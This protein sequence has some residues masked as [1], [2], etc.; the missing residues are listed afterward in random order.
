MS[1]RLWQATVALLFA[2][3]LTIIVRLSW[4]GD[5]SYITLRTI[6]NWLTGNGLTWNPGER[7][8][9]YTHP[10]WLFLLAAGRSITGEAFFTTLFLGAM[11]SAIA[12]LLLLRQTAAPHANAAVL[13]LLIASRSFSD[14]ATSGLENPLAYLLLAL[15]FIT[16]KAEHPRRL[17]YLS[18]L[19][20][21]LATTRYDFAL[22]AGPTLLV[23]IYQ[24]GLRAAMATAIL[25][26]VPF[27]LWFTFAVGYYGTPFPITAYAKAFS[28]GIPAS[29]LLIQGLHY[30]RY[31]TVHEPALVLTTTFGIALGLNCSKLRC[32]PLAIGALLYTLY[33]VKVGGDFMA[34]RFLTSPF[35]IALAIIGRWLAM[36]SPSWSLSTIATAAI[37]T[38]MNGVPAWL[39]SPGAEVEAIEA[40]RQRDGFLDHGILD[41]RA[42]YYKTL[43]LLSPQRSIPIPG[44]FTMAMR[45][46]G[47]HAPMQMVW[48]Q[49]GRFGY[50]A[51]DLLSIVDPWLC[52]PLL[53]RLPV[54]DQWRIGHF[55][56][57]LPAGYLES[58]TTA[59]ER[60]KHQGLS[61]YAA[62]LRTVITAPVLAP[63]RL[64]AMQFLWCG[65]GDADLAAYVAEEYQQP[66][67]VSVPV[68]ALSEGIA[69]G[70]QWF[71]DKKAHVIDAGG[72]AIELGAPQSG[73]TLRVRVQPNVKYRFRFCLGAAELGQSEIDSCNAAAFL[74][75]PDI[76][77]RY[78]QLVSHAPLFFQST[79]G[80]TMLLACCLGLQELAVP[81]PA[82]MGTFDRI[83]VD[84]VQLSQFGIAALGMLQLEL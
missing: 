78:Q 52:D 32:R 9:T 21:L 18:L 6:E 36:Q 19:T 37:L 29:E 70:T 20:A 68:A 30:L 84:T 59:P 39:L 27:A 54:R 51:G 62:T 53:M 7:V 61:R 44:I 12:V 66:P 83:L 35:V 80:M 10:L 43:G 64:A 41:E 2:A 74:Q 79:N 69:I 72:L 38:F 45:S 25:G 76:A 40:A 15:L 67:R 17:F 47:N 58:R 42:N 3:L 82:G 24:R 11:T 33:V 48:G 81:I 56:R 5:D 55:K 75:M 22:L 14:Y 1:G 77:A 4:V 31:L 23:A 60:I 8:Q 73:K 65:D 49:V 63:A 16:A 71:A 57:T 28:H 46:T 26:M 34:G 50:E 13:S